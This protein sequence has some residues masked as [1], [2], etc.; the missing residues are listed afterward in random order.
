MAGLPGLQAVMRQRPESA[1][2][3]SGFQDHQPGH[4]AHGA[5]A[6]EAAVPD[7]PEARPVRLH[8]QVPQ[9]VVEAEGGGDLTFTQLHGECGGGGLL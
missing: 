3:P 5:G 2:C 1:K 8:C 4:P 9:V 6:E 7:G